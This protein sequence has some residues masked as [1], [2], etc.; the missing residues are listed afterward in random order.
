M[1]IQVKLLLS[2]RKYLPRGSKGSS[3]WLDFED[4]VSVRVKDVLRSLNIPE[5][6]PKLMMHNS[7]Q[8]KQEAPLRDGDVITILPPASGG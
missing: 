5:N 8:A 1:K 4:D 7:L 2:L 3:C 6:L